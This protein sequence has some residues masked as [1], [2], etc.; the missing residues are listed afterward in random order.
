MEHKN[1]DC[2]WCAKKEINIALSP[3]HAKAVLAQIVNRH[4]LT[5]SFTIRTGSFRQSDWDQ[6]FSYEKEHGLILDKS[7]VHDDA[8]F[9]RTF[10][11]KIVEGDATHAE[12][13]R[14]TLLLYVSEKD[15]EQFMN[16]L[17]LFCLG[18]WLI[19]LPVTSIDRTI[20]FSFRDPL[21]DES[22]K[23]IDGTYPDHID[24]ILLRG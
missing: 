9:I 4:P 8:H 2:I 11:I 18:Y 6:T 19:F 22:D 5:K 15:F 16:A 3:V 14:D 12:I 13:D 21:T 7:I 1:Y 17:E 23:L 10:K 20:T 24:P